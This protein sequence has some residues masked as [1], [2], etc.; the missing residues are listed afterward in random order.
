MEIDRPHRLAFVTAAIDSEGK[1]MFHVLNT[2]IFTRVDD[3]TEISLVA[4]VTM[5][6]PAA[7]QYLAGMSQGWRQSLDRLAPL[8]VELSICAV[9]S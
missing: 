4:R 2:V 5:T 8:V 6:T 1:P 9:A 3:G 7:P